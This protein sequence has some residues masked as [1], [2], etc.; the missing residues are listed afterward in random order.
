MAMNRPLIH[1]LIIPLIFVLCSCGYHREGRGVNLDASIKTIAVP[2]F[3]NDTFEA[4]IEA[5]VTNALRRRI[6]LHKNARLVSAEN[7]S[8]IVV[9]VISKFNNKPISFSQGDYAAEYR[10]SIQA[11]IK[12]VTPKGEVLWNDSGI[13]EISDYRATPD[14]FQSEINKKAAIETIAEKMARDIH[15]RIFDG[16]L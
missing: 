6:M 8:V 5:A 7:A 10:A 13:S 12:L 11:R 9:G 2:T 15:D 1:T 14:I 3:R 4:G 16:F